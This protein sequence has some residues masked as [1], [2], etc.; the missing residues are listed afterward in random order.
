MKNFSIHSSINGH[1]GCFL[2]L[3]IAN[4]VAMNMGVQIPF[5]V[6]VFISSGHIPRNGIARS[7]D[8][9]IFNV[10]RLLHTVLPS[11]CTNLQFHQQ[12]TRAP[13]SLHPHQHLLSCLSDDGHSNRHD[14][15]SH[16]GFN[17]HFS[18]KWLVMFTVFS[19]V[20]WPFICHLWGSVC[21][22]L[23][24]IFNCVI[25]GWFFFSFLFLLLSCISSLLI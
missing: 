5:Q 4:Y 11:G 19:C 25:C 10:L 12:Y 24:P 2:V 20:C 16:C 21:Q 15:I 13:F 17:M 22:V 3:T 1:L 6:N 7:Y 14:V 18:S 23:C 9:F 8:S